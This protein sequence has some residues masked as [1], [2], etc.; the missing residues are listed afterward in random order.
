MTTAFWIWSLKNTPWLVE[1]CSV[2]YMGAG[3]RRP[4]VTSP[5]SLSGVGGSRHHSHPSLRSVEGCVFSLLGF[6]P[7]AFMFFEIFS[8]LFILK[9]NKKEVFV[10]S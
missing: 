8:F 5:R 10:L 1:T 6:V 2:R 7:F 9:G 3:W 4:R